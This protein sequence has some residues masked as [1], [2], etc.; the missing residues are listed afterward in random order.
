MSL[1]VVGLI[2]CGIGLAH[3]QDKEKPTK[4]PNVV[5]EWTGIWGT[6]NI[7]KSAM[8]EK[9]KCKA[10]DCKVVVKDGIWQATF[11]G[12]CGRPYKYT[13]KMDGRQAGTAVLFKGSTD[14]G[15]K[16]GGAFDWVGRATEKEFVGF[17]TSE[18]YT[19]VFQLT[20]TK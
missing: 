15:E 11:E 5:G 17:Y 18:R 7:A 8:A 1:I 14:L 19:G 20:R 13:I 9:D 16:D 12:E 2:G 10:I 3:A 6:Y 4:A